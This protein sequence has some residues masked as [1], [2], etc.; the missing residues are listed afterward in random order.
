[1]N[2]PPIRVLQLI[3]NLNPGGAERMAVQIA[4]ELETMV[5]YTAICC[6]REEGLLKNEINPTVPYL[7]ANRN[8]KW[9]WRGLYSIH[10]FIRKNKISHLHAH[11]TSV[12]TAALLKY[13]NPRIKLIWHDHYGNA[14][15]LENRPVKRLKLLCKQINAIIAVNQLLADW[16]IKNN[17]SDTVTYLPNFISKSR[18]V[19]AEAPLPGTLCK[20]V[21]CLA[22][23]RPQKNQLLLLLAWKEIKIQ[24]PDW[25]LLLVGKDFK[26]DYS[27][28][29]HK[30]IL[31]NN[32]K[33]V[34]H[35]LGSR[36]DIHSLLSQSTIGVLSSNSEGLPLALLEYGNAGLPVVVT[37]VGACREVVGDCGII[38]P[39]KNQ[40]ALKEAI[41]NLIQDET[42]RETYGAGLRQ[43]VQKKYSA[44]AHM[45]QLLK[46]YEQ[47][48]D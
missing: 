26:D 30:A 44:N 46:I 29:I 22:N 13:V 35:V 47:V 4:N 48:N 32:L 28:Q 2:K 11:S 1:M 12:Y 21:V 27:A 23:L 42:L 39:P 17:W 24:F 9:E 34:V 7:F 18:E 25:S 43:R 41:Q 31:E 15:V 8:R 33:A 20:R 37:G 16:S 36:T 38:V 45:Q 40:A 19:V 14:E 5:V 10:K 3:D 6:T